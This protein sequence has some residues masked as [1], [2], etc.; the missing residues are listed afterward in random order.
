M[1]FCVHFFFVPRIIAPLYCVMK[2][3]DSDCEFSRW[4]GLQFPRLAAQGWTSVGSKPPFQRVDASHQRDL[5]SA[6]AARHAD[7]MLT[8]GALNAVCVS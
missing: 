1:I 2:A 5:E 6:S 3:A 7:D 4:P 8:R